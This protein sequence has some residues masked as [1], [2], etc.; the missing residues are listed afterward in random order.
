MSSN[1]K[2]EIS[3]S[4]S[5]SPGGNQYSKKQSRR[6]RKGMLKKLDVK[7]TEKFLINF[8]TE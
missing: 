8:E 4:C 7:D 2:T 5:C 3:T 1:K 6:I